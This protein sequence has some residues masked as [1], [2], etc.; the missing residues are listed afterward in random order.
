[1]AGSKRNM[2]G[3]A[4]EQTPL[5][6]GTETQG[7]TNVAVFAQAGDPAGFGF[8][9]EAIGGEGPQLAR[10]DRDRIGADAHLAD[11]AVALHADD[12]GVHVDLVFGASGTLARQIQDGAPFE[13]FLASDE[14][15][16]LT[17]VVLPVDGGNELNT[18]TA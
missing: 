3:S 18:A 2:A 6:R 17:G 11:A 16:W 7:D 4:L 15:S 12:R 10:V 8:E 5:R 9:A 14:A 13:L 1:M